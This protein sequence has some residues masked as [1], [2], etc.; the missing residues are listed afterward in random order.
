[1]NEVGGFAAGIDTHKDTHALCVIDSIGRVVKSGVFDA[2]ASGYD[3][4]AHAIGD[5]KDCIV[6]V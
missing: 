3:A 6:V 4:I 2:K 1:M 5:P